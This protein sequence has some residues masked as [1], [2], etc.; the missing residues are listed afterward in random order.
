MTFTDEVDRN[1]RTRT[2]RLEVVRDVKWIERGLLLL[3]PPYTADRLP[4]DNYIA[5]E[6]QPVVRRGPLLHRRHPIARA[7]VRLRAPC[8]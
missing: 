8:L 2:N 3:P 1:P 6:C 4:G 7:A 5:I